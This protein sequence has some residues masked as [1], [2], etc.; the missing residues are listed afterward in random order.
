MKLFDKDKK[1]LEKGLFEKPFMQ[2]KVTT[3]SMTGK[4]KFL[5]FFLGP[6]GMIIF[7]AMIT[8]LRELYYTSVIPIDKLF[9]TGTYLTITTIGSVLA[10]IFGIYISYVIEH[11]VSSA[12]KLKPWVFIGEILTLISGMAM[13]F[14]PFPQGNI[15]QLIWLALSNI[16]Y[17]GIAL[18]MYY[19]R[20]NIISL[21]TRNLKDRA[22]ITT[23]YTCAV[24]LIPGVII[25]LFVS[26]ILYYNFLIYD[27]EGDMWR[28]IVLIS[29]I[30]CIPLMMLEYYYTRERVTEEERE[31]H[32]DKEGNI[33]RVPFKTQLK[34]LLTNKY[35]LLAT[36][37]AYGVSA[38]M[39]LQGQNIRTNYCQW[40]LG[41]DAKNNLQIIYQ[42]VAMA[43][44]GFGILLIFPLVK[45]LGARKVVMLGGLISFVSAI[46]CVLNPTNV[47][48]AF[49][50]SF[51]FSFGTLAMTYVG[52]VFIQQANDIIEYKYDFRPEGILSSSLI[53]A[54]LSGL[55]SPVG[56]LYETV[57]MKLGYDAYATTQNSA[58]INWIVFV[59][60]GAV[61][62]EG[63]IYFVCLIFFDAEKLIDSVQGE[64]KE[65]RKNAVLAR[66]GEWI[67]PEELE[68]RQQEESAIQGEEDR[69]A[70]LKAKCEKKGLDFET[71]N[72][73]YLEK[74]RKKEEKKAKRKQK[75]A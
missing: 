51:I 44:M 54:V 32:T 68:R 28:L 14:C 75:K 63:L 40:V 73:K 52:P 53:C 35:W 15:G 13:F 9:G 21:V 2:T 57:L 45:K 12:G 11:T 26:S 65:R 42:S 34:A 5:G 17:T 39:N 62:I 22:S 41:A 55:I 16:C 18:V 38:C 66:G 29:A 1:Y 69:I 3:H 61:A 48:I 4:E 58:V 23:I 24:Q 10:I 37:M 25:G 67:D 33:S 59:W 71:E 7:I 46:F 30:C 74:Q 6:T 47:T 8:Q 72:R 70:D 27:K 49:A 36:L 20:N 31:E 60:F 64:L 43:P 19:Q 50:G 56:G